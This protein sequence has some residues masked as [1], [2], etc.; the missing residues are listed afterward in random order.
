LGLD[1]HLVDAGAD[2]I[3]WIDEWISEC[4]IYAYNKA[5]KKAVN[6]AKYR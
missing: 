2:V 5:Y 3:I 4:D 1:A 6:R